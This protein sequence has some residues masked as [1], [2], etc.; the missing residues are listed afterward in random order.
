MQFEKVLPVAKTYVVAGRFLI[1]LQGRST[2]QIQ[3]TYGC[4]FQR[5]MKSGF[6]H[7]NAEILEPRAPRIQYL[8][9]FRSASPVGG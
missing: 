5:S 6:A 9:F 2:Q 1:L 3:I 4:W 8:T 7:H